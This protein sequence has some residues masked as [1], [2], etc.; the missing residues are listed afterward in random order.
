[1]N[2][3]NWEGIASIG[4]KVQRR[5]GGRNSLKDGTGPWPEVFRW[6]GGSGKP[7]EAFARMRY[8]QSFRKTEVVSCRGER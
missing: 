7:L 5:N 2:H 6:S 1:M 4:R 3:W 8:D